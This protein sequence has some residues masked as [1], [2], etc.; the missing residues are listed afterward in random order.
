MRKRQMLAQQTKSQ[1]DGRQQEKAAGK[2][3]EKGNV[4]ALAARSSAWGKAGLTAPN[5]VA[6]VCSAKVLTDQNTGFRT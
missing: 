1:Y 3:G 4:P 2:Q 5:T 6:P